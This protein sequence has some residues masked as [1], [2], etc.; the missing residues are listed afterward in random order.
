M[1]TDME[2][3]GIFQGLKYE[4]VLTPNDDGVCYID[5]RKLVC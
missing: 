1:A 4:F 3:E 5:V 2:E